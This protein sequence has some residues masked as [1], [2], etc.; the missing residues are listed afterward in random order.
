MDIKNFY[1]ILTDK[2]KWLDGQQTN[3]ST[4]RKTNYN[5]GN[6]NPSGA[7]ERQ[8]LYNI[9]Y[10]YEQIIKIAEKSVFEPSNQVEFQALENLV[11]EV[12][13]SM[14]PRIDYRP[15]YDSHNKYGY[16]HADEQLVASAICISHIDGMSN[17]VITGD[18]NVERILRG[19]L[20]YLREIHNTHNETVLKALREYPIFLFFSKGMAGATLFAD[21]SQ[22]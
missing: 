16:L 11:L 4:K 2:L 3:S 20:S 18:S 5:K 21:T 9:H 14:P 15:R 6:D 19:T 13:Q 12:A 8:S 1:D 17:C 7:I 22:I 10:L